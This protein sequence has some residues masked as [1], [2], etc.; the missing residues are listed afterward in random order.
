MGGSRRQVPLIADPKNRIYRGL[1]PRTMPANQD[2]V[3]TVQIAE[4][5]LYLV[6]CAV[7]PHFFDA[8]KMQFVMFGYVNVVGNDG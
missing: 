3:E 4:P 2:R 8:A 5:G 1:D 6:I 7:L